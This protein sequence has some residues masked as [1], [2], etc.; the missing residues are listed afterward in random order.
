MNIVIDTCPDIMP[1]RRLAASGHQSRVLQLWSRPTQLHRQ[2]DY[3]LD[4]W[5]WHGRLDVARVGAFGLSNGGFTMLVA[6]GGIP[7]LSEIAPYCEAH[8]EHDLCEAVKHAGVDPHFCADVPI[9]AWAHISTPTQC[10][11][12]RQCCDRKSLVFRALPPRVMRPLTVAF[13]GPRPRD[14]SRS[15]DVASR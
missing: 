14:P 4:E 8:P 2:V 11:F 3:M 1:F 6:A 9:R 12:S 13:R 10:S 15:D 7:D 5:R